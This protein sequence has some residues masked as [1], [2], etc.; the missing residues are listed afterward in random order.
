MR[1]GCRYCADAKAFLDGVQRQ[2]PGLHIVYRPVDTDCAA[3]QELNALAHVHGAWPPGV[4]AFH[5]AG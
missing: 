5:A 3:R 2:R 4:P 1:D